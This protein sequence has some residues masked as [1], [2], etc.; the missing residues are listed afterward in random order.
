MIN[1]FFKKTS[2]KEITQK[3][4]MGWFSTFMLAAFFAIIFRSFFYEPFHIPSG[5]MKPNLL[6]G[7]YIFVSKMSYGYTKYSLP[8]GYKF[9]YFN[10]RIF[11]KNP[12]RGDVAVFRMPGNENINYIKRII[13]V[14][15]DKVQIKNGQIFINNK[16][17]IQKQSSKFRDIDRSSKQE[18]IIDQY[19]ESITSD[20][21]VLILDQVKNAP[22]DNSGIYNVPKNHY[23]VMGDNRDNSRDSRYIDVGFIPHQNFIGKAKI[24]FFSTSKPIWYIFSWFDSIRFSR[25]FDKIE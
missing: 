17:I 24:I 11:N 10:D 3:E 15:G 8:F 20:K 9:N 14:P 21:N 2:N 18:L 4:E 13:G 12:Q 1:N 22:Q 23:F 7:D 16:K 5:S 25:I 19:S 6:I